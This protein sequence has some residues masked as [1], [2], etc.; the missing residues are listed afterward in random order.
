MSE[1]GDEN[2][3]TIT[4]ITGTSYTVENLTENAT[5]EYKVMAIGASAQSDWSNVVE[6]TLSD[7]S[8]KWGDVNRDGQVNVSDVTVLINMIL[9]NLATDNETADVN[10]DGN[11]NVSDVTT[12]I[13]IILGILS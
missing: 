11:V 6:V 13:N 12:L 7:Q 4:G 5:Y 9:G 1:S 8:L 10:G 3:R 2:T